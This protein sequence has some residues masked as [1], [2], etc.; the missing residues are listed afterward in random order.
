MAATL[1]CIDTNADE[2]VPGRTK[3][4]T[5]TLNY[6]NTYAAYT[7]TAAKLATAINAAFTNSTIVVSAIT[8]VVLSGRS[9][10]GT[11]IPVVSAAAS[12]IFSAWLPGVSTQEDTAG[13]ANTPRAVT[14]VDAEV[15]AITTN[16]GTLANTPIS[17]SAVDITAGGT[18]G[19][20]NLTTVAPS[21]SLDVQAV[22]ST[23]VLNTLAADAVT[24]VTVAYHY[25]STAAVA[26]TPTTVTTGTN[27]AEYG[28]V[29]LSA[30]GKTVTF[31][32]YF[33]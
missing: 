7:L 26:N 31:D 25:Q 18:T 19:T 30:A 2:L 1:T 8:D 5:C 27:D 23:G 3:Q 28:A 32:V 20:A 10:D 11:V 12:P 21:T 33:T 24:S 29:D 16:T 6:G 22:L 14:T 13:V 17:I 9:T 15:V 4:A